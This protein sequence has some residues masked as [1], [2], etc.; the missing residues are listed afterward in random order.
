M[1]RLLIREHIDGAVQS[2]RLNRTRMLLTTLGV[3]I[4]VAS[5]TTILALSAGIIHVIS[6]QVSALGDN[7]A[8]VRPGYSDTSATTLSPINQQTYSTST[9]TE[10]DFQTIQSLPGVKSA[11]PLMQIEGMMHAGKTTRPGLVV[12]TTPAFADI[13][14]L[15]MEQGQFLDSLTDDATTVIGRQ[16]AI[17][18]F[19]TEEPLGQQFT[20]RGK[21]F[22]VIGTL[23]RK[24]DP[25]NYNNIDYDNTAF[26]SLAAGKEF[27]N[28]SLQMQ[29][30]NVM[31]DNA[32]VLPGVVKKADAEIAKNHSGERDYTIIAGKK[33]ADSSSMLFRALAGVMTA[34]AAISLIVG[35][36]G[37][38]NIMLVGVAERTREIGLRKAVGAT[39]GNIVMQ[40]MIEALII[41]LLGG[42]LGY[43]TGY[44]I[45]FLIS[46]FFAFLPALTWHIAAV[47]AG[48]S[49][50]V[51]V[52]F[53]AYPAIRAA[54]KDPIESLRSYH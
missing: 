46:T 27:H 44:V 5:I 29:Q 15:R 7:I 4:G 11:A 48:I 41:S 43:I 42:I 14:K 35:G 25:V 40:F 13:A 1:S 38:M 32:S 26:I 39:N 12:A 3:G 24:D 28:G 2:L 52:L 49:I 54:R 50:L 36:I 53:G 21:T 45:A 31:A 9:L 6:G 51:G 22:T 16:L 20:I 47:A 18:V 23:K 30:I 19:G 8:V 34:I 37:I 17:N 33:I 10:K